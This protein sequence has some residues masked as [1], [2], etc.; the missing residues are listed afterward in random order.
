MSSGLKDTKKKQNK[1]ITYVYLDL[2]F[3]TKKT[4]LKYYLTKQLM[5]SKVPT[6]FQMFIQWL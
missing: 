4:S 6:I 2:S 5:Y 1:K 3:L